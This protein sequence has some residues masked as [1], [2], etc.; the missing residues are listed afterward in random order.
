MLCRMSIFIVQLDNFF[1]NVLWQIIDLGL[2]R[3]SFLICTTKKNVRY[4]PT[5]DLN[6]KTD[7]KMKK[8]ATET[9]T[10]RR[11]TLLNSSLVFFRPSTYNLLRPTKTT[12]A[13]SIA[14]QSKPRG[15]ADR[16]SCARTFM[17][18]LTAHIFSRKQ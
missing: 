6:M 7:A 2:M 8:T 11:P 15:R 4:V 9:T 16:A 18:Q 12:P 10:T 3:F 1:P 14:T 13:T 17:C 5:C